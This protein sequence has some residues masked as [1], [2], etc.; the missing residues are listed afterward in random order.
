VS[1]QKPPSCWGRKAPPPPA[2]PSSIASFASQGAGANS[3][4]GKS[5]S[6]VT[7]EE[8]VLQKPG[9]LGASNISQVYSNILKW[10]LNLAKYEVAVN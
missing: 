7:F 1:G 2:P 5:R 6:F 3:R 4:P 8:R 10:K 9:K